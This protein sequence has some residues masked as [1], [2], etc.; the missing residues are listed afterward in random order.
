MKRALLVA[1]TA[2]A[3]IMALTG[4]ALAGEVTG[5]QNGKDGTWA[6]PAPS[7][8][9]SACVYSGLEDSEMS[10]AVR[11]ARGEVQ[12]WGHTKDDPAVLDSLGASWVQVDL[13]FLGYGIVEEGCN[14]HVGGGEG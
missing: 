1:V 9:A 8:A 2:A 6:T 12:N 3:M 10:G 13:S 11:G 14:P 4:T 5:S 7:R